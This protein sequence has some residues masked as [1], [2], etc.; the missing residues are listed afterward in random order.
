[1]TD[2]IFHEVERI[3]AKYRTR[4]PFELLD[5]MG[6]VT[7]F[8]YRYNCDGLKGYCTAMLR[9]KYAVINANLPK[10]WQRI[11]AA[12]E[13]AHLILH[14]DDI[15]RSPF[16]TLRDFNFVDTTGKIEFQANLFTAD[17]L[18]DDDIVLECVYDGN[19]DFYST[20][21]KLYFPPHLFAFKIYSMKHRG[22][23]VRI[24]IDLDSKFLGK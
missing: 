11:V 13:G 5:G 14:M 24:P 23:D 21:R 18:L 16:K 20:A 12:H 2:F 8:S 9:I 19:M 10:V 7:R 3:C 22:Y 1:M 6:A 4:D 17:F 15:L